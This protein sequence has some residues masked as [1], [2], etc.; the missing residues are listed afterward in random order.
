MKDYVK[1]VTDKGYGVIDVNIPK[2]VSRET[3]S[4]PWPRESVLGTHTE[5]QSMGRYEGEDEDR[6]T[7]TEELAGY[8]W[9]N[10][11]E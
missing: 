10:Y 7:A 1:W 3:V 2:H 9:D 5:L 11:I 6:P 8:L 4:I